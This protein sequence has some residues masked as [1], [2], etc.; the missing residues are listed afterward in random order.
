MRIGKNVYIV[1]YSSTLLDVA[2][3]SSSNV[4]SFLPVAVSA[5]LPN[6]GELASFVESGEAFVFDQSYRPVPLNIYVQACGHIGKNRYLFD[7]SLA[8]HVPNILSRFSNGRPTIVFCHSKRETEEL[9]E[10]LSGSWATQSRANQ[11]QLMNFSS[12]TNTAILHR[13]LR[14]GIAFHHAGLDASDRRLVE[15]AFGSGAISC[16]CATSTL[17]MGVNLPSHLVVIKGTSAYRGAE[18]GH[19]D[20]DAGTLMQMMGR[21]G[22]PGFDKSGTAVI[23][24]DTFSKTRYENVSN[25]YVHVK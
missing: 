12:K 23:M 5:T 14:K 18:N 24:T 16:L 25:G 1:T 7:K 11:P 8:Q 20:I 19:Q 22:R 9:A 10:M 21:A 17:A 13:C 3:Q 6:L 4:S 2:T 15:E